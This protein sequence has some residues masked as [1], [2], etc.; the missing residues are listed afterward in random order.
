MFEEFVQI[1]KRD[2]IY[3]QELENVFGNLNILPN[4]AFLTAW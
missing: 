3:R 2:V 1:L 4:D